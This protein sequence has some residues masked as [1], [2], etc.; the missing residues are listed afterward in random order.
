MAKG[1]TTM[2]SCFDSWEEETIFLFSKTFRSVVR[3]INFLSTGQRWRIGCEAVHS[4][5]TGFEVKNECSHT[6]RPHMF[7]GRSA[8][9][10]TTAL[11]LKAG[12]SDLTLD[13]NFHSCTVHLDTIKFLLCPT[14]AQ[15]NIPRKMLKFT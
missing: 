13:R 7:S 15:L 11:T 6:L 2:Q 14:D 10:S 8:Q 1:W 4:P 9:S 3:S 5:L 12:C